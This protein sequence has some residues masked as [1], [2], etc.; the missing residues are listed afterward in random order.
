MKKR[1]NSRIGG[2]K[3][4]R[5]KMKIR[6]PRGNKKGGKTPSRAR[7]GSNSTVIPWTVKELKELND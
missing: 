7:K 6:N 1:G 5:D 4:T 2:D 3:K